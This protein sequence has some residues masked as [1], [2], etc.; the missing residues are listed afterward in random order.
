MSQRF[1]TIR[2]ENLDEAY[3]T[4]RREYSEDA[5]VL[6]TAR[7]KEGGLLGFMGRPK[8]ELTVAT[9]EPRPKSVAE[10]RYSAMSR[11][12]AAKKE[13]SPTLNS[14]SSDAAPPEE[15]Q[16][17]NTSSGEATHNEEVGSDDRF[18]STVSHFQEMLSRIHAAK[19]TYDAPEPVSQRNA[20]QP[21]ASTTHRTSRGGETRPAKAANED[22]AVIPFRKPAEIAGSDDAESRP[23]IDLLRNEV[24]DIHET[25]NILVTESPVSGVPT[26]LQPY[27]RSFLDRGM[28]K[29]LAATI[30]GKAQRNGGPHGGY[31]GERW[32]NQVREELCNRF[33]ETG[34][35]HVAPGQRQIVALVGTTGVGKTTTL[36]KLASIF[37]L[38][39]RA[40]VALVTTD[41]YRIGAAE[42][43]KVYA[44]IIGLPMKVANDPNETAEAIRA[45]QRYELVLID[46]VGGS[47]FNVRHLQE[48]RVIL[49]AAR[50][51]ET[52]L[53]LPA[54]ASPD[55]MAYVLENYQCLMPTSIVFTKVDETR[56]FGAMFTTLVESGLPVSYLCMGQNVPDDLRV[57]DSRAIADLVL[58]GKLS[59]GRSSR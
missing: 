11:S 41:T 10:K 51:T 40:K 42:Q 31:D 39:H 34:G 25:L 44:D 9:P 35:I 54:G 49:G 19:Q 16:H 30:I 7:I 14:T 20:S 15:G 38:R 47:Q 3:E 1:H 45:F 2:A 57:A 36:A 37:A 59:R 55:D 4:L 8:V 48:L 5:V 23:S 29:K 27:Y 24:R 26:E 50:P 18:E 21:N 12:S 6:R 46:T 56:R 52:L 58:E 53:L 28:D 17:L 13:H 32:T 43:L 22:S 33:E